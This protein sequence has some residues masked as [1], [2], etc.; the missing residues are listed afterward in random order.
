MMNSDRG[1]TLIE[2]MVVI[3][4][5]AVTASILVPAYGLL[6]AKQQFNSDVAA[7]ENIITW[8]HLTAAAQDEDVTLNVNS[9]QG[10][11][12]AQAPPRLHQHRE[13]QALQ[14]SSA[15]LVSSGQPLQRTVPLHNSTSIQLR[16]S[17]SASS[18]AASG[19][20][21]IGQQIV[22]HGDGTCDGADLSMHDMRG[23]DVE[24]HV[25]AATSQ[26]HEQDST[27]GGG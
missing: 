22:F 25:D 1:F 17:T 9:Q 3:V 21:G 20:N 18:G 24:L 4:I 26:V 2:I 23:N 11:V 19:N 15:A 5:I 16:A 10:I 8:A 14:Q 13:P 12:T 6:Y 7:V 27:Q